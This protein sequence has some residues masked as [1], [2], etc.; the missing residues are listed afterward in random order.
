MITFFL[1][2]PQRETSA[3]N[4]LVSVKGVKYRRSI[5]ESTPV[6]L[7][8]KLK[9]RVK[10]VSEYKEANNINDQIMKW[11]RAAIDTVAYFKDYYD[12][13]EKDV[14]F[15]VLD[16]N[17]YGSER[18]EKPLTFIEYIQVYIDRYSESKKNSRI[19]KYI[20]VKNKLEA[21]Q[22]EKS[23]TLYFKDIDIVFYNSFKQWFLAQGLTL[24]YF[25][26]IVKIIKLIYTEAHNVDELHSFSKI[27]HKD[28]ISYVEDVENI[29]L[30]L[31]ELK[32]I[33][34]YEFT[35]DGV[36]D[37]YISDGVKLD[38]GQAK[39]RVESYKMIRDRFLIGAY[40][41]LR[42]SDFSRLHE[43]NID[44]KFIRLRAKKTDKET[45]IPIN[46]IV[47]NI[48]ERNDLSKTVS[49]QK[50]NKHIKEVCKM[51]GITDDILINKSNQG[52]RHEEM[53]KKYELVTTHTARRSFATNAYKSGVPTIAIMKITGHTKES[54][55]LKYIKVSAE[56]N[57]ELLLAHDF[58]K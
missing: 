48:I 40:T 26:S 34:E 1:A 23:S 57:A 14:F 6:K 16:I 27:K 37:F 31:N 45:V 55:F 28:F 33:Y 11:E 29:Y 10:A 49:D 7:W 3:I 17:F 53:Y 35:E 21:Y 54:T 5:G 24:N 52:V 44:E 2:Q 13:P 20:N 56:E 51:V 39:S 22:Q 46:S 25:G 4:I 36:I 58:F 9:K 32:S 47:R 41:G 38:R 42:V 43:A 30:D 12:A 8:N 19:Q 50:I 15:K 18:Q